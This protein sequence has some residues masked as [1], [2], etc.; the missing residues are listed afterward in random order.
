M[1]I[2]CDI[3]SGGG[4]PALVLAILAA[5]EGAL[6]N[7]ILIESDTRKCAFLTT[8]ITEFGLRAT[9]VSKRI[10]D[11]EPLE[12]DVVSARALAP[13]PKLLDLA[14]R[15]AKP[16]GLFLL[17][18]GAQHE[19]EIDA[20]RD[21]WHFNHECVRSQTHADAVVLKIKEVVRV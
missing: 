19:N 13:L 2:W 21:S 3:G 15:H 9:V 6:T 1:D 8:M 17:Q 10:E 12:A 11:A 20:A 16:G 14:V 5:G 4:L 18:K 7:F